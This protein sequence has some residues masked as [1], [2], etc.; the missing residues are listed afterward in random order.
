M[1]AA[2]ALT[3]APVTHWN[4]PNTADALPAFLP[5]NFKKQALEF[6]M[7]PPFAPILMA[8]AITVNVKF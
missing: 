1:K 8:K 4:A 2:K 6:A 5:K 7:M 3:A